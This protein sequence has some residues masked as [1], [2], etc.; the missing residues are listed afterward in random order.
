MPS[1]KGYIG[2]CPIEV[3][4]WHEIGE[5]V[6]DVAD[7]TLQAKE[8]RKVKKLDNTVLYIQSGNALLNAENAESNN[9][10]YNEQEKRKH[11][12]P[13]FDE[14]TATDG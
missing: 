5:V 12:E 9:P 4:N 3:A 14:F 1:S 10:L 7:Q 2:I 6:V 13:L 11:G 8:R